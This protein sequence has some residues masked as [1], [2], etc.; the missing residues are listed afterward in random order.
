MMSNADHLSS[1]TVPRTDSCTLK[2]DLILAYSTDKTTFDYPGT[3]RY[4][5]GDGLWAW[6]A[7]G[8]RSHLP[9]RP[10]NCIVG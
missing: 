10:Y 5:Q 1:I 4:L 7:I 3:S 8:D 9:L 6:I 2:T